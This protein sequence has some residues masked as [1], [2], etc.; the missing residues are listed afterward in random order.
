MG[1]RRGSDGEA[2]R[3]WS[4]SGKSKSTWA[5]YWT[6]VVGGLG[7]FGGFAVRG[8]G[9]GGAGLG[10]GV[11]ERAGSV[12]ACPPGVCALC[13]NLRRWRE[14]QGGDRRPAPECVLR[15]AWV[16]DG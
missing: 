9:G 13:L 4:S 6:G 5:P 2:G 8:L 3:S 15:S 16:A 14:T 1:R 10:G 7:G 12:R 11:D